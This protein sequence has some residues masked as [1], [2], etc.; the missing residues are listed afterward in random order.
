M[1]CSNG[2]YD[3]QCGEKCKEMEERG[4]SKG[5]IEKSLNLEEGRGGEGNEEEG[6]NKW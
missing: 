6:G 4:K 3:Q 5:E 1:L 2:C